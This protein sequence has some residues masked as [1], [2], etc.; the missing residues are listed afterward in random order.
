MIELRR[1]SERRHVQ[2]G[3]TD[4]WLT[5]YP[6][7]RPGS[8]VDDFGVLA[9][10]DEM[11]IA[12]GGVSMLHPREEAEIVIYIYKGAIAQEDSTGSSGVAHAG[13]FQ[14]MMIGAGI[15]HKETN[16]SHMESAHILRISLRPSEAGLGCAHEQKHFSA[17][18][19]RNVLCP[20]ASAD[21][22]KGSLRILQDAVIYSSVLDPGRHVI[23]ELSPGRSAWL[24]VIDGEAKLQDVVLTQGDGVGVTTEP[25]VSLT[26][27]AKTEILLV[28]LGPTS[29][30][31]RR[32]I[33]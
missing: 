2:H 15:R 12:P 1:A 23:H 25:S 18:Q 3:E 4:L 13:E 26:A 8:F 14:R 11:R 7:E 6:H 20:V 27:Q 5:F 19:R 33:P 31:S 22:R 30:W 32:P 21:G 10:F 17:A 16:A 24:H 29:P 28:D 9:A